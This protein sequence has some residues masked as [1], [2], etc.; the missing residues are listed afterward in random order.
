MLLSEIKENLDKK[1]IIHTE[2]KPIHFHRI[3]FRFIIINSVIKIKD[4][5]FYKN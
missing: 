2:Q 1:K 4:F 5:K 3:E